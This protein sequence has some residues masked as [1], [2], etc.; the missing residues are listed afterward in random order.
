MKLSLAGKPGASQSNRPK[1]PPS[2]TSGS[3]SKPAFGL[4]KGSTGSSNS[5]SSTTPKAKK[6]S[7]FGDDQDDED[8]AEDGMPG[9]SK[10]LSKLEMKKR[11]DPSRLGAGLG[12]GGEGNKK[13]SASPSP[14][15]LLDPLDADSPSITSS[16]T[17][18]TNTKTNKSRILAKMHAEA[19]AID[20]TIFSYD[21]VY[22]NMKSA[23][24]AAIE[25]RKSVNASGDAPKYVS[26]LLKAA[27]L[28][29]KDRIRAEDKLIER[30]R[31][32]EGEDF[33]DKDAFVTQ[34]YKEQQEELR[35]LEEEEQKKE[36]ESFSTTLSSQ[37]NTFIY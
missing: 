6:I 16:T 4:S 33:K 34:A 26:G 3:G 7:V 10:P 18:S 12:G 23:Q 13:T 32:K 30:E 19:Q 35:R 21:E 37:M 29:K 9:S 20:P 36:G 22:D 1:Q 11:A 25:A 14:A 28:R 15:S 27:E 8:D 17:P 5:T 24:Q 2:T 31:E